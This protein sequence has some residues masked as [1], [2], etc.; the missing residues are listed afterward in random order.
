MRNTIDAGNVDKMIMLGHEN[1]SQKQEKGEKMHLGWIDFSK[2]DR[3]KVL[4]VLDLLSETGTLDELGISPIRDGFSNIFF[5]GTSTIQTRAK[6]FFIVPYALKDLEYSNETNPNRILQSLDEMERWCGQTFLDSSTDTSGIIGSRSLRQK[7]WVKRT[8][9]DIYWA[10]LRNYGIFT[11]GNLSL[12]EYVRTM[13]FQKTQKA[14]L[15]KLGNRND[16]VDDHDIDDKDAGEQFQMRFWKIPTYTKSWKGNLSIALTEAEGEYLKNQII[17]FYPDSFLSYIIKNKIIEIFSCESFQDIDILIKTMPEQI[18]MDYALARDFSRFLFVLQTVYNLIVS[19]GENEKADY[20][21]GILVNQI[22]ALASVD[23]KAIF[24]R[25]HIN[26]NVSL[27]RFLNKER[28]LM[29]NNDLDGIKNEIKRRER[30]LKQTRA[31]TLHPGEFDPSVWYGG[32]LLDYRF[33]NAKVIIKDI[34]E[35]EGCHVKSQ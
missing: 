11:G 17:T 34:F 19:D 28:E 27:H 24:S 16:T 7:R 14:T 33:R 3:N 31:K 9:A 25:L 5:P 21:W 4:S 35:S 2:N 20:N 29:I 18:Q 12:T 32:G 22:S 26:G 1:P 15:S 8:P 6:Y 30:E 23:L 13:C 10:G